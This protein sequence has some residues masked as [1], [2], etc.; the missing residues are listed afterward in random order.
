V[1]GTGKTDYN[2]ARTIAID[3]LGLNEAA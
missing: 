3:S 1:L 2:S